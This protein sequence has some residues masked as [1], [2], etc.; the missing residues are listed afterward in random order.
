VFQYCGQSLG[1]GGAGAIT[2]VVFDSGT[3][4]KR[5]KRDIGGVSPQ[6]NL[7]RQQETKYKAR[8]NVLVLPIIEFM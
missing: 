5:P 1:F 7:E 4:H 6:H 3:N 2:Y 8:M